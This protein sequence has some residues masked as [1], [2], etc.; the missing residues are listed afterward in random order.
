MNPVVESHLREPLA[1]NEQ[2]QSKVKCRIFSAEAQYSPLRAFIPAMLALLAL[3]LMSALLVLP[4]LLSK[5]QEAPQ[6]PR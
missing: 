5:D 1:T 6:I 2:F 3:L 4:Q